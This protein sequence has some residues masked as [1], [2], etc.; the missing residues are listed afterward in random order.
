MNLFFSKSEVL[1]YAVTSYLL[2]LKSNG[3]PHEVDL[4]HGTTVWQTNTKLSTS[5]KFPDKLLKEIDGFKINEPEGAFYLFPDISAILGKSY[6]GTKLENADVLC[7]LILTEKHVALV[8][9]SAFG[10]DNCIRIA[11][12][13]SDKQLI[14]AVSRIKEFVEVLQ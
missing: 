8:S 9:G 1:R 6:K 10:V 13:A 7:E 3:K 12:S 11:Y 4:N 2:C 5:V 14:E